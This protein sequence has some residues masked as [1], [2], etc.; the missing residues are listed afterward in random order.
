MKK[1]VMICALM[2]NCLVGGTIASAIGVAPAYG[3]LVLNG[4][5]IVCGN[6]VPAGAFGSSIHTEVWTGEM[7][8]AFRNSVEALGWYGKIRSYDQ[9]ADNEVIHYVQLGGDPD[10]LINNTTYPIPIQQ[11]TDTGKPVSLDKYQTKVTPITDDELYAISYDK[12]SSVIERHREAIDE[13]KYAMAIHALAPASDSTVTPVITTTGVDDGTGRL[14]I[15]RSDIIR[16]K[17]AYDKQKVPIAGRILVL[18][19]EHVNDLLEF[20]QKFAD[21][22]YNYT[23]GKIANI[24][25]F[26]IYEYMDCPYFTASTKTKKP[27]GTIPATGDFQASVSFFAPRA[28]RANGT[29]EAYLSPASTDPE[30]QR[31]LISFRHYSICLPLKNDAIGAIVS[32]STTVVTP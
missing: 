17:K 8:K 28:M 12:M 22:Y 4:I 27:F 9:Y 23:S 21:Q 24:H 19:S 25:G 11:I 6:L 15:T 18:C 32:N 30:N 26:E 20:D 29:T 31:S 5:G 16:L 7:I 13:K 3:A 10:V 1:L 14:R 2:A